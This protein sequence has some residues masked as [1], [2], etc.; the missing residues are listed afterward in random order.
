[1]HDWPGNIREL[2]NVIQRAVLLSKNRVITDKELDFETKTLPT[3]EETFVTIDE[4]MFNQPLKD[5][6]ADLE[7]KVLE[8]A[9][10]RWSGKVQHIA[11]T[12]NVGKTALYSKLKKYHI[13]G[14]QEKK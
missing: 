8:G 1:M 13:L 4:T 5:T 7:K 12:L 9:M 3:S 2:E 11:G 6:M 10:R 14:K